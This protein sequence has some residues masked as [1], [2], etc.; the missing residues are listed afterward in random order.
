MK[1]SLLLFLLSFFAFA[2]FGQTISIG[3]GTLSGGTTVYSPWAPYYGY[4]YVQTIYLQSEINA[5]G[6]ITSIKYY[7]GG[8]SLANSNQ[9]K[10]YMGTVTRASFSSTTNWEPLANLTLV[11]DG[12]ITG[13]IPGWVTINLTTPFPYNNTGNLLIAVDENT[14]GYEDNVSFRGTTGTNRV[15]RYADDDNNPDPASPP[16]GSRSS[17]V[18]NIQID[19]LTLQ[20]CQPVTGLANGTISTTTAAPYWVAPT[21][22][23]A[24][25]QYNW[26]LRTS[27]EAGSGATGLVNSGNASTTSVNLS[28]LS[29]G[30]TYRFYVRTDCGGGSYSAWSS[31]LSITTVCDAIVSFPWNENFDAITTVGATSFPPCWLK[32]G[33]DWATT[34]NATTSYDAN[35]RSVPNFL[36]NGYSGG[37]NEYLWTPGFQLTA[38]TS[39]DFSFWFAGDNTSGW[40][41]DILYNTT[42]SA[43]GVTALGAGFATSASPTSNYLYNEVKRSFVPQASGVYYFA[44]R[45]NGGTTLSNWYL[46]FDDFKLDLTPSCLEPATATLSAVTDV[47]AT[48]NWT[49]P[50]TGTTIG[51]DWEVRTSGAGG[52]GATGLVQS[53]SVGSGVFAAPVTGLS[54]ST[55]YQ[56]YVRTRCSAADNSAWKLVN[57]TTLCSPSNVGYTMPITNV[58]APA[59][60][61]CAS[62]QD[63][64][65]DGVTW[66]SFSAITGVTGWT[67]PV[68]GYPYSSTNAGNDWLFTQGLSLTGGTSYTLTFKYNNDGTVPADAPDYWFE[69]LKVAYGVNAE[70]SAMTLPLADYPVVAN[71]TP[72]T[73]SIQFTPA[74]TGT[75]YIGFQA[76]SDADQDL[77]LL[78]DIS[79][80]VT[81]TVPVTLSNFRGERQN[82]ANKLFWTTLSEQNND[83]FELQ[84]SADGISFSTLASVPSKAANGNSAAALNYDFS[85]LKPFEGSSY[86]RLKQVDKDGKST[87]SQT[88]LIKSKVTSLL[89]S[90][91]YPNPVKDRLQL[92]ISSPVNTEVQLV[93][94]DFAGRVIKQVNSRVV[95][96]ENQLQ[97]DAANLPSGTYFIKAVCANGCETAIQKFIKQ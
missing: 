84:R 77:L 6:S 24:V 67:F 10:I 9:V 7:Y 89:F 44:L 48:V 85:D 62:V 87:V 16:T 33:G 11:Y 43:T 1:K 4:S 74:T 13:T 49:A 28:G 88:V 53:G 37:T 68:V 27:G 94:T 21:G 59:L 96:G 90:S 8:S 20:G 69:K 66:R 82:T 79:V 60:P 12:T 73:A 75:Y 36:V 2:S 51:Y 57:F 35:A 93:I 70:A 30:T 76:Y 46:S 91:I 81:G 95:T 54:A 63:V 65:G 17:N 3:N 97:L 5:A 15:L 64:N 52:S 58:T 56:A 38:G 83:H 80:D 61:G 39:Y 50:A 25:S 18:G 42:Q 41:G 23:S 29:A 71:A 45:I 40:T 32:N 22:G 31:A 14:T 86:Y 72:Q 47:S 26:E 92:V 78:D 19:G 34:V 55:A